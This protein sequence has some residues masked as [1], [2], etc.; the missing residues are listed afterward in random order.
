MTNY[1]TAILPHPNPSPPCP[2]TS[3][4]G[5]EPKILTPKLVFKEFGPVLVA[6]CRCHD[7]I[8]FAG[9]FFRMLD[10]AMILNAFMM[11][12]GYSMQDKFLWKT[13]IKVLFY[14]ILSK[15]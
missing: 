7:M 12:V 11:I 13:D 6:V 1:P 5:H 4:F 8:T 14:L 2:N 3:R 9:K 10:T 15:T